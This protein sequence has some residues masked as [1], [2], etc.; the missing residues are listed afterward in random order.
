MRRP[1]KSCSTRCRSRSRSAGSPTSSATC[2]LATTSSG[3][4]SMPRAPRSASRGPRHQRGHEGL[5]DKPPGEPRVGARAAAG[6]DRIEPPGAQ[7]YRNLRDW[8]DAATWPGGDPTPRRRRRR[9]ARLPPRAPRAALERAD[10]GG[11]AKRMRLGVLVD[12]PRAGARAKP[13]DVAA[14]GR[15]VGA[16]RVLVLLPDGRKKCSGRWVD[17]DH[18]A[19]APVGARRRH[20]G[21][22]DGAAGHVCRAQGAG[23]WR[24]GADGHGGDGAKRGAQEVGSARGA[25]GTRG[26][27]LEQ[28]P[29]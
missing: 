26:S 29:A 2:S 23:R 18:A 19:W 15:R 16:S 17:V 7:V 24:T 28:S 4:R 20:R 3:G 25:S 6:Q 14:V 9:A 21:A 12:D 13:K 27:R 11:A 22:G 1:S 8:R 10:Q 5:L